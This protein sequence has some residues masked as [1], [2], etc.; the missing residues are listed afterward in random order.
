MQAGFKLLYPIFFPWL[1]GHKNIYNK[2]NEETVLYCR[3]IRN[4]SKLRGC[5]TVC[6]VKW[7]LLQ[8][9][10]SPLKN[11][12]GF[13]VSSTWPWFSVGLLAV[14]GCTK[15]GF[16]TNGLL[17]ADSRVIATSK[18]RGGLTGLR[19]TFLFFNFSREA[20]RLLGLAAL[21]GGALTGGTQY[22]PSRIHWRI[23]PRT[24]WRISRR[25]PD[26]THCKSLLQWKLDCRLTIDSLTPTGTN[27][28][29]HLRTRRGF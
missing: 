8:L 23:S 17:E 29:H 3:W 6:N 10:Q 24:R 15:I 19:L 16:S 26:A 4:N 28:S 7:E 9:W 2:Y 21:R 22:A 20:R 12:S 5:G 13:T 27:L 14:Q 18:R 25:L 1:I 11:R